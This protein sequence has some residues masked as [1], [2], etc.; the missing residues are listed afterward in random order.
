M[1]K[2]KFK[3]GLLFHADNID[4]LKSLKENCIDAIV[5]DPPYGIKFMQKH[6]DY[7]IPTVDFWKEVYRV[8]KPGGYLL[9]ACGTK[10]QHRMACAIEDGGFEI[11]DIVSWLYSQGMPKGLN[12][13]RKLDEKLGNER[14]VVGDGKPMKSLGVMHDDNWKSDSGYKQTRGT[15]EFEGFNTTLKPAQELFTL[16][17]KPISEKTIVDNV[18]KWGVGGMNIDACRIPT[19]EVI[20]THSRGAESAKSKGIYGDSA[21]QETH[22]KSGQEL[23]R[24]PANVII[25]DSDEVQEEFDKFGI[26]K[27][28]KMTPQ[29][30]RHTNGSPNGIY[31]KQNMPLLDTY[32]DEGSVS[33]F[34][35][36][37]KVSQKERN[38]GLV[39]VK[40]THI[41]VKPIALM[42]YLVTLITPLNGVVLDPFAGT[43]T[44]GIAAILCDK[45]YF[46]IEK[47]EEYIEIIKEKLEYYENNLIN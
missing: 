1:T 43:G 25:D 42:K 35:Y 26:T 13:G 22:Q 47:E 7:D 38:E 16:A 24:F 34:F 18:I 20:T 39:N 36:C 3:N 45:K 27:S 28:G 46:L 21:E 8:L 33:R 29:H 11:K 9:C 23:G 14:I 37:A 44:T 40:N 17:Q 12:I 2:H 30:T 5:T 32:A 41:T 31:G 10:T 4:V 15:S 6:W 19:D